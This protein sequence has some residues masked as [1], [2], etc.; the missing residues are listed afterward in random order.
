MID[1][2]LWEGDW[3]PIRSGGA[4]CAPRTHACTQCFPSCHYCEEKKAEDKD[5]LQTQTH[6]G[7]V[8]NV[9]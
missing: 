7:S 4:N 8:N 3:N 1:D 5:R 9:A 2:T 6:P